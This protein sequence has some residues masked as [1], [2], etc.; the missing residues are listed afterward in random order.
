MLP[1]LLSGLSR[2]QDESNCELSVRELA[3]ELC[4]TVPARLSTLLTFVP[5]MMRSGVCLPVR[6]ILYLNYFSYRSVVRALDSLNEQVVK[7]GI[8]TFE[9]WVDKLNHDYLFEHLSA[10]ITYAMRALCRLLKPSP[11]P[12]GSSVCTR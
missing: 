11:A 3:V 2:L 1:E 5:L 6:F 12:F 9:F 4:L 8:R 7:V 10:E